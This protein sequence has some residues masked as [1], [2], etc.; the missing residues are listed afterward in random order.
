[1]GTVY[2]AWDRLTGQ[3]VALKQVHQ[4]D[5][6]DDPSS[7]NSSADLRL[8]LAQEFKLLAA[9]HH[10]HI[11]QVLDYGFDASKQPF[12]TMKLVAEGQNIL[13]AAS[14]QPLKRSAELIMQLLEALAYL[15]HRHIVHCDVK[16]SNVLV[17]GGHVQ[18]LDFG[19]SLFGGER[20]EGAH[21][22]AGTLAYL[23]PEVLAGGAA[24]PAS[25]LYSVG[26]ILYEIL[27]GQH[28]YDRRDV[29]RMI[30]QILYTQPDLSALDMEL[31]LSLFVRQLLSKLPEERFASANDAIVALAQAAKIPVPQETLETRESYLQP[32]QMVGRTME[33]GLLL[34]ALE[35]SIQGT[36][37]AWLVSGESGVGKTRLLEETRVHAMVS[38]ATV[39]R[40]NADN[41]GARPYQLWQPVLSWLPMLADL[42]EDEAAFVGRLTHPEAQRADAAGQDA[43]ATP[44][45]LASLLRKVLARASTGV[46][47]ILED[48]H[49][50]TP[51]N[52]AV[53]GLLNQHLASLPVMIVASIRDDEPAQA[54]QHLDGMTPIHLARLSSDEIRELATGILGSSIASPRLISH[55]Q[56]ETEGNAF[57]LIEMIRALA[58]QAG[59][60]GK[61][62]TVEMP[63][64]ITT[65][66]IDAIIG[67]RIGRVPPRALPLLSIAAVAGRTLDLRL[68]SHLRVLDYPLD[69]WIADGANTS[70]LEYQ[71]PV[72]R[73]SHERVR[74]RLRE[75]LSDDVCQNAH[76]LIAQAIEALY[77]HAP[78]KLAALAYHH[79]GSGNIGQELVFSRLA[80]DY[81]LPH[82]AY[83]EARVLY[84][85]ILTLH[86]AGAAGS[87][88]PSAPVRFGLGE[89]LLGLGEYD[90]A[91]EALEA[92]L[93][94]ARSSGDIALQAH[95]LARLGDIAYATEE[96]A[97][98]HEQY[99]ASLHIYRNTG[100]G[101]G[102]ARLLNNLGNVAYELGDDERAA[103]YFQ[104]SLALSRAQGRAWG[105]AGGVS[106]TPSA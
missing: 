37:S 85:R 34:G 2:R 67:H 70:V 90:A 11:I 1:M 48:I 16:P 60:F 58:N 38:G 69:D 72:W 106:G 26:I 28:P 30:K 56:A 12:F 74:D 21:T 18:V 36:G 50:S 45:R 55:L 100:D 97:L 102:E 44:A 92:A 10:P 59:E 6:D 101:A 76:A 54:S 23:A 103:Q 25:D 62:A 51:D 46:L 75:R 78:E 96:F 40:A 88:F 33:F 64:V 71:N 63:A 29:S 15:H 87:D 7:V 91:R 35:R 79:Q 83:T 105:M 31:E 22:T 57:F 82:G 81:A 19:L 95:V 84:Q 39:I 66:G 3:H 104:E 32:V 49:W 99:T 52:L 86:A 8:S 14:G 61:I 68:L 80:A 17:E 41:Q 43:A 93:Q 77:G 20:Q 24:T 89:A 65:G 5:M 94:D 53:L 4:A 27:V 13:E 47:I 9:V 98:A 73:F 42:T